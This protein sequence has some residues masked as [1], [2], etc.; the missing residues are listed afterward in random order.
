MVALTIA[1][2]ALAA[3]ASTPRA[4]FPDCC[5]YGGSS[6][7]VVALG[8]G[9]LNPFAPLSGG[10]NNKPTG[11]AYAAPMAIGVSPSRNFATVLFAAQTGPNDAVAGWILTSN[12][13]NDVIYVFSNAGPTPVCTAGV[14]PLGSMM[15]SYKFCTQS[16]GLFPNFARDFTLTPTTRVG[17]FAQKNNVSTIGF[18]DENCALTSLTGTGSPFGTGAFS[19]SF[20]SGVPAEPPASWSAPPSYCD[21]HW[22]PSPVAFKE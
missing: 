16:D 9:V 21:G 10:N 8:V 14:G 7:G 13:T 12:A 19:I 18:A 17:L 5:A 15:P 1:A 22:P 2:L 3:G 6:G 20:E 11:P 4:P